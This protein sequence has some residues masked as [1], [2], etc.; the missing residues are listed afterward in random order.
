MPNP[1][2]PSPGAV[3]RPDARPGGA[4]VFSSAYGFVITTI[5]FAVGV[6]TIWRFPYMLGENGGSLY[7]ITYIVIIAVIC[8]PLLAAEM[9]IGFK[10]RGSAVNAYRALE[11]KGRPWHFAG[12]LHLATA[13]ILIGYITPIFGWILKY[14]VATPAGELKGLDAAG[15]EAY[16]N[17]LV[18]RPWEVAAFCVANLAINTLVVAGG[19]RRGVELL[20]KILLPLLA[21]VMIGLIAFGLTLEG[22]SQGLTFLLQPDFSKFSLGTVQA[23]L[24]QAFFAVGIAMLASMMFGSYVANPKEKIARAATMVCSSLVVAGLLAGF[25]IFPVLFS[26]GL[27]P[28]AG[29]GLVF[30][31]LPNA[32]NQIPFGE[33]FG[34]IFYI[35]FYFAALTSMAGVI[36]ACVGMIMDQFKLSRRWALAITLA[37]QNVVAAVAVFAFTPMFDAFD[38]LCNNYL[39]PI[40]AF[41][42]AVFVGWVWGADKFVEACNVKSRFSQVFL[43]L[44]I[45]YLCPLAVLAVFVSTLF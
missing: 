32:F 19:V 31:T 20:S 8:V 36:E 9:V 30:M 12:W 25:M 41:V 15:T 23:A 10:G 26:A 18:S 42:I 35:G 16:F 27:E 1:T 38:L 14:V 3:A 13:L 2:S 5:G 17:E 6:G 33:A 44:A 24:G 21:V 22:G 39:L 7:L 28:Q 29:P 34:T 11:P 40:G 43:K 37:I 45:K 4:N